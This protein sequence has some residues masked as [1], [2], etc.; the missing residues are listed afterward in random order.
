LCLA[1]ARSPEPPTALIEKLLHGS[2]DTAWKVALN[3]PVGEAATLRVRRT[4]PA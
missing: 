4:E 3:A 1:T 2:T